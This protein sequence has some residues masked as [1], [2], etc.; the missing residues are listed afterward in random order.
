M[1]ALGER[2]E[3]HEVLG[4]GSF[5]DV[6]L[7]TDRTRGAQVAV[8]RLRAPEERQ[9]QRF[10]QEFRALCRLHHPNLVTLYELSVTQDEWLLLMEPVRGHSPTGAASWRAALPGIAEGLN[11][12]HGAGY[13]H[14]DLKPENLVVT[15]EGRAVLL[16]F[17]VLGRSGKPGQLV[18]NLMGIAPEQAAGRE[19]GP[20]SDWYALGAMLYRALTGADPFEGRGAQVLARKMRESAPRVRSATEPAL[21]ELT[22]ALLLRDPVERL[23]EAMRLL[24]TLGAP[25]PAVQPKTLFVGRRS[26]RTALDA[27]LARAREGRVEHVR[28]RGAPGMGKSALLEAWTAAHPRAIWLRCFEQDGSA[29][30]GLDLVVEASCAEA[31]VATQ[32]SEAQRA[33]LATLFP[34]IGWAAPER[35]MEPVHTLSL[36]AEALRGLLRARATDGCPL[37]LVDDVQWGGEDSGRLIGQLVEAPWLV[38]TATRDG[39]DPGALTRTLDERHPARTTLELSPLDAHDLD[40]SAGLDPKL[41][42]RALR[43]A[44]GHPLFLNELLHAE[45]SSSELLPLLRARASALPQGAT[46]LMRVLVAAARP[47]DRELALN[48]YARLPES[49]TQERPF[50]DVTVLLRERMARLSH[51]HAG[52]RLEPTH[53]L[54]R[55]ACEAELSVGPRVHAALDDAMQALAIDE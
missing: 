52:A 15:P 45:S 11:A 50:H 28:I 47:L 8:K 3:V 54:I 43:R 7:A 5:G 9:V 21:A 26:E 44:E 16:D 41:L 25:S 4:R 49:T 53:A 33:A 48:A 12:L 34:G 40:C 55:E 14:R 29:Y 10:K 23:A 42:A 24:P 17:G 27:A 37:L 30:A 13:L 36:A 31:A 38:V 6:Y 51:T 20:A 19:V 32:L 22:N 46:S 2:F 35:P 39:V 1:S 18:G